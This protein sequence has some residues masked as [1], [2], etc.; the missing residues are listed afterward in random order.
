M[1]ATGAAPPA[2][3]RDKN[4]AS[5]LC[6][7][8]RWL[9]QRCAVLSDDDG[10]L[11]PHPARNARARRRVWRPCPPP[12]KR[13]RRLNAPYAGSPS[14]LQRFVECAWRRPWAASPGT[15]RPQPRESPSRPHRDS[16]PCTGVCAVLLKLKTPELGRA[17]A[18]WARSWASPWASP[19]AP[20]SVR[21]SR[22]G[23]GSGRRRRVV[24]RPA[25]KIVFGRAR[26]REQ[27]SLEGGMELAEYIL[28]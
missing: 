16:T 20:R 9:S 3:E 19:R 7:L 21:R 25:V 5:F 17:H 10:F 14:P 23:H 15:S 1:A 13:R 4:G 28:R 11:A 12:G 8:P 2:S 6:A 24:R 26:R 22:L 18:Q 27:A